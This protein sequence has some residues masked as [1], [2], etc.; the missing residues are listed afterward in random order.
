MSRIKAIVA[1]TFLLFALASWA[2][3]Q[4]APAAAEDARFTDE[5]KQR[6]LDFLCER[7]KSYSLAAAAHSDRPFAHKQ[8]PLVHFNNPVREA[9]SDAAVFLWLEDGRPR[10]AATIEICSKGQISR[11]FTSLSDEP[12]ECRGAEGEHWRPKP[13]ELA[14]R[15]LPDA[16]PPKTTE[17]GRLL[18]M[19]QL[20]RRFRV[21]MK[22]ATTNRP[23]ELRL[24][25]RPIYRFA[26]EK[27]GIVDGALYAFAEGTDP[28]ALLLL[29]AVRGA[30]ESPDW[31]YTLVRMT[32]RPLE[33]ELDGRPIWSV[34]SYWNNPRS[35]SDPYIDIV[36]GT[37][38]LEP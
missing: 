20:A 26:A 32:S 16:P 19:G 36:R 9:F 5:A 23:S 27:A 3:A 22:E 7:F 37:Y 1:P 21:V 35:P 18:Q 13:A 6:R 30:S 2:D 31:Q 14:G 29:E 8:E 15:D 11:E 34:L 38:P 12:L 25:S 28:E 17:K 33:A 10:A 4:P 24:M